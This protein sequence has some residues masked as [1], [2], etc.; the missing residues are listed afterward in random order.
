MTSTTDSMN[1]QYKKKEKTLTGQ[2]NCFGA[3]H[4]TPLNMGMACR[5]KVLDNVCQRGKDDTLL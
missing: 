3:K 1:E 2:E 5:G 4:I